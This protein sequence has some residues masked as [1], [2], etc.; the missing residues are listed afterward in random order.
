MMAAGHPGGGRPALRGVCRHGKE[1]PAAAAPD[2]R[3]WAPPPL[4]RE[5]SQNPARVPG[6]ALGVGGRAARPDLGADQGEAV[7]A[8]HGA[9]RAPGARGP[10]ADI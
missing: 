9:G 5:E 2:K 8:L 3:P 1:A 6:R 4:L 10:R 7:D